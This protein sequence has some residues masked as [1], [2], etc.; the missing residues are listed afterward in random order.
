MPR[1]PRKDAVRNNHAILRAAGD[2]IR[3]DPDNLTIRAVADRARLSVPTVYRYYPSAEAL[4]GNYLAQVIEQIRD[5]SHDCDTAGD[6]L[7]DEVLEEWGRIIDVY[8]P[9][10]V[11]L[12]S[13]RGFLERLDRGDATIQLSH[14]AWERP[15]RRVLR[16]RGIDDD[17]FDGALFLFNMI[18]DPR[19]VLDLVGRNNTMHDALM[20]L[21]DAYLGAISGWQSAGSPQV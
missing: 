15:I 5:F 3:V 6:A 16:A 14:D 13:R 10:L 9:A 1:R 4:L 7:F 2:I 12:R 18:F 11:Q 19:E 17:Y 20:I 8:G 21:K